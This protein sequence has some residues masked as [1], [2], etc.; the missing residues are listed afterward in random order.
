MVLPNQKVE[1]VWSSN[2]I[3]Y[4]VDKGYTYTKTRDVFYVDIFD[5]PLK[6]SK[7]ITVIC[8]YCFLPYFPKYSDYNKYL[9]RI[10]SNQ[11]DACKKC[12]MRKTT[13]TIKKQYQVENI[14][15]LDFVKKKKMDISLSKYGVPHSLLAKEVKEKSK[16][17]LLK[18]FG[19]DHNMKHP[20]IREKA[21]KT[22]IERFG[23]DNAFKSDEIKKK[24]H[25]KIKERYGVDHPSQSDLIKEKK[26]HTSFLNSSGPCSR[27]QMFIAKLLCGEINYPLGRL[28]LDI[29][30]PKLKTCIEY[31]GSG[32]SLS[33][34]FGNVSEIEFANKEKRRN[35]Y[36]YRNGWKTLRIISLKDLLPT[37]Y[38]LKKIIYEALIYLWMENENWIQIDID[39]SLMIT[40]KGKRELKLGPVKKL[41]VSDVPSYQEKEMNHT[42]E[43]HEFNFNM[44]ITKNH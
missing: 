15:Q 33:V 44:P 12:V 9:N 34:A 10:N 28:M 2:M 23:V 21:K 37:P 17:T 36:I 27:Q 19:V 25:Q 16:K 20:E 38:I 18:K 24:I 13:E 8:D 26:S 42:N 35:Y 39:S 6:S 32:H 31:D 4:Y 11:T 22:I 29:A 5:L 3:P 40:S 1:M 7:K 43:S 14:S 30:F 41:V